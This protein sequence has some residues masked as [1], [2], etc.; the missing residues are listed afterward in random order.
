MNCAIGRQLRIKIINPLSFQMWYGQQICPSITMCNIVFIGKFTLQLPPYLQFV[1]QTQQYFLSEFQDSEIAKV[2]VGHT[3][4]NHNFGNE[5]YPKAAR[6]TKMS[7]IHYSYMN[8]CMITSYFIIS[9]S[10]ENTVEIQKVLI[11]PFGTHFIQ[12]KA[13]QNKQYLL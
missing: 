1:F 11:A 2:K 3:R 13:V 5:L 8:Q 10:Y 9:E 12:V 6:R 4:F 7:N